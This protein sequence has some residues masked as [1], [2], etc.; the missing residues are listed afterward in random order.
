[1]SV[2][3]QII[4]RSLLNGSR[5]RFIS[6]AFAVTVAILAANLLV[7]YREIAVCSALF[8]VVRQELGFDAVSNAIIVV[9]VINIV[10]IIIIITTT[11]TMLLFNRL[12]VWG[13]VEA[14]CD[15]IIVVGGNG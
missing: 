13:V 14:A 10:I 15:A 7:G 8:L 5:Y 11:T 4:L 6:V 2:V 3:D 12:M 1:M 9:D